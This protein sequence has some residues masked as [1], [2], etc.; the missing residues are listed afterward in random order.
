VL[1]ECVFA[2][3]GLN[4]RLTSKLTQPETMEPALNLTLILNLTLALLI[5]SQFV[6]C[7]ELAF[8]P[9]DRYPTDCEL[10]CLQIIW[11]LFQVLSHLLNVRISALPLAIIDLRLTASVMNLFYFLQSFVECMC[12]QQSSS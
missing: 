6:M 7:D 9:V 3:Q 11:L 1:L 2:N 10:V 12:L 4:R 8:L 5:N